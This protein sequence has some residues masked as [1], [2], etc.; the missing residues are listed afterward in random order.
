MATDFRFFKDLSHPVEFRIAQGN[1]FQ[2]TYHR[3][4]WLLADVIFFMRIVILF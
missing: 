1:I 2:S 4:V 3:S